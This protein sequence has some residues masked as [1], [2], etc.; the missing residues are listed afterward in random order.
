LLKSTAVVYSHIGEPTD[1]RIEETEPLFVRRGVGV[2]DT[3]IKQIGVQ[4]FKLW[5]DRVPVA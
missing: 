1:D 5:R 2:I 4:Y 3:R